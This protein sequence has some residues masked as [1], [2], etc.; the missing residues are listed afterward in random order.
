MKS[1]LMA[2]VLALMTSQALAVGVADVYQVDY[3]RIDSNNR[4]YVQFTSPLIGDPATCTN[5]QYYANV[6]T[7]DL[8]TPSGRAVLALVLQAKATG[9][10]VYAK[11]RGVCETYNIAE[12]WS[13]GFIQ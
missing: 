6:L 9:A 2:V 1:F 3:V 7:F 4:G 8:N 5:K 11:G 12:D 10:K 13:W